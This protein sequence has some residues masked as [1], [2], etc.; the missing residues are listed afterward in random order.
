MLWRITLNYRPV[1]KCTRRIATNKATIM[2]TKHAAA[3]RA[4]RT[5]S[6]FLFL[7]NREGIG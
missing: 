6:I 2:M 5:L 1:W 3:M 4:S 7:Q